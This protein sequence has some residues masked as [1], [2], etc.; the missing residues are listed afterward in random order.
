MIYGRSSRCG[1]RCLHTFAEESQTG[2]SL[3][4]IG[5]AAASPQSHCPLGVEASAGIRWKTL[6]RC[7]CNSV[8]GRRIGFCLLA[9]LYVL[10]SFTFFLPFLNTALTPF[11]QRLVFSMYQITL[12]ECRLRSPPLLLPMSCHPLLSAILWTL[13]RKKSTRPNP[14]LNIAFLSRAQLMLVVQLPSAL[15]FTKYHVTSVSDYASAT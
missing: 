6:E 12:A 15:S 9:F 14:V 2:S 4:G 1:I 7:L 11:P 5:E 3:S 13:Q 10:L 8:G